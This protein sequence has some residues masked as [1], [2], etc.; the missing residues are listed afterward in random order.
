MAAPGDAVLVTAVQGGVS[1]EGIGSS[2]MAL[3][4]FVRLNEGDRLSL[5]AAGQ[6]S[7]VY[8]SKGRQ[9]SW[10]GAGSVVVGDGESKVASGKPQVQVRNIPP[11][12]AKQMN[13]TPVAA[14]DGK[15]GMMRTR[16]IPTLDLARLEREYGEMRNQTV[17]SDILPEVYLLSGLFELKQYERIEDELKRI[18][19]AY[20]QDATVPVLRQ[21]YAKALTEV[22]ST[23]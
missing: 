9:E 19:G 17:A 2:K 13:R 23:K 15:V 14:A 18:T 6:V 16:S 11:S 20:P 4:A 10:Q 3:E 5:P 21:L 12:V 1:V 22:R 7:L 8:V